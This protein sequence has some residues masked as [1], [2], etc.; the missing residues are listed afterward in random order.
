[1]LAGQFSDFHGELRA[2][3]LQT[4]KSGTAALAAR[5]ACLIFA[6]AQVFF[7]AFPSACAALGTDLST[8]AAICS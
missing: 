3:D 1:M 6:A 7:A 2:L 5:A 4:G 8:A